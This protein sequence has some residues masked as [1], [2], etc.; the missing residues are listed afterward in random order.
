MIQN[1]LLN[2]LIL[3]LVAKIMLMRYLK[4]IKLHCLG[5]WLRIRI[6]WTRIRILQANVNLYLRN[7]LRVKVSK[8][9]L[10]RQSVWGHNE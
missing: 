10:A 3:C 7:L 9:Q 8:L 6:L 5:F 2:V 1:V 4:K